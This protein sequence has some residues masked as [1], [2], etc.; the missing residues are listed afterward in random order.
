M[1]YRIADGTVSA[2]GHT[3]LSHIDFEIKG[4]E[5]IALVGKNGAGK[6]TL[7]RLIA[8]EIDLER[9]DKR[10]HPGIQ[11]DRK[12]TVAMLRQS[13]A[14]ELD[15]TVEELIME[16]CPERDTYTKE[17]FLYEMEYDRLFTGFGFV[18]EQKRKKLSSFSGGEQTKLLLIRLL[19]EKPDILLLDEPTN[20]LDLQTIEWLEE[21]MR[22]YDSAVVFV[23][24]DR[25]FLDQVVDVVYELQNGKLKRY[26]G[27]YSAYRTQKQKDLQLQKK[28]Y[29]SQQQEIER[30]NALIERFKNKP[31]KAAFARSRKTMLQKMERLEAPGTDDAHMFTGRIEPLVLGSKCVFEA[32][33]LKIGYDKVLAEL[34]L[35][36]NRG[37]KI[38]IIGD[39]GAGKTTLLKTIAGQLEP[40]E[41]K[42]AL[43]NHV[44][45]GYFEQQSASISSEK[46]VFEHFSA[47]FPGIPEKEVRQTLGAYL[48]S[49][50]NA[51]KRVCDLSGGEKSRLVLAELLCS[52]PNLLLLDEPTNHMDIPAKETLESAFKAYTG[53][54]LFVSHDRYFIEQVADAILVIEG[55][56]VM[57]YP[58]GYAHYIEHRRRSYGD[59]LPAMIEAE[60]QALVAELKAVPK[61]ERHRLK[62][63]NTEEAYV[64]WKLRLAAEPIEK[65]KERYEE[66][67]LAYEKETLRLWTEN[68]DASDSDINGKIIQ[69]QNHLANMEAEYTAACFAWYDQYVTLKGDYVPTPQ[70]AH[71]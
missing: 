17:R 49:G 64:D 45:M 31:K 7:L 32:E 48:F 11:T 27:N 15:K 33:H 20:H 50:K 22:S 30:L 1:R 55:Q 70:G 52:R 44:L 42:A 16:G 4:T 10:Q 19:L 5:K 14:T 40:L 58:F 35:R 21:Y 66:A 23:S 43:G 59:N 62:E 29:E 9:D 57:Y 46:S 47:L 39:N 63:I 8:G 2:G 56:K 28:A 53:T 51:A 61:A 36:V 71:S 69:L 65:A 54:L 67:Y 13:N 34:S 41:G 38:G 24:H 26:V 12:V 3:I 18:K 68:L 6:T 25:F 37:Q 60:N